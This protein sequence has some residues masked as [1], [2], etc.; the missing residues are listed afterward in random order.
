MAAGDPAREIRKLIKDLGKIPSE[1]RKELRPALKAAAAPIVA[2]A[3]GRASW[4]KRIPSAITLS[5]RLS[6]R[7][8]GVSIH[9]RRARAPHGR[10]YEGITGA[11][12]FE[13]PVF[14][15]LDRGVRQTVRPYLAPAV[16]AGTD[17]VLDAVAQTV[18]RVAREQGFR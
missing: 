14:G 1:L 13:H 8:P 15:H 18:D 12:G 4:S 10:T 11:A 17:E 3:R 6:Q 16:E 5:V 9:V 2:D 7:R